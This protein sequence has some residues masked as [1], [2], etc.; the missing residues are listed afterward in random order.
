[1]INQPTTS[2][3]TPASGWV[4]KADPYVYIAAEK[5]TIDPAISGVL[6]ASDFALVVQSAQTYNNLPLASK[7]KSGITVTPTPASNSVTPLTAYRVSYSVQ[8]WGVRIWINSPLAQNAGIIGAVVE[9]AIGAAVGGLLG[10]PGAVIGG[11]IGGLDGAMP[12]I[13]DNQCGNRGVYIDITW[14][15]QAH[16][17]P[18][19]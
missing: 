17:T 2:P 8:W 1:M 4:T 5:A 9:G 6:S 11:I 12:A 14:L 13:L 19:C 18:V 15:L 7:E 16:W 3:T 10:V